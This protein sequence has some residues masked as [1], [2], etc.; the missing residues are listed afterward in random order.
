MKPPIIAFPLRDTCNSLKALANKMS[1]KPFLKISKDGAL[2]A[3]SGSPFHKVGTTM[4]KPQVLSD[5]RQT[6]LKGEIARR[7]QL[8]INSWCTG[9][10][11]RGWFFRYVGTKPG[12]GANL[13]NIRC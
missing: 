13:I 11:G 1:L 9:I 7:W 10:Y 8:E 2:F 5:A 4:E 3:S 12:G 6:T